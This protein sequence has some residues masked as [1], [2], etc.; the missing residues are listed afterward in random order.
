MKKLLL[1][2]SLTVAACGGSK[3][4]PKPTANT[5]PHFADECPSF[6]PG[7]YQE[8]GADQKLGTVKISLRKN[9][10]NMI[11]MKR[12]DDGEFFQ[13][14]GTVKPVK[15]GSAAGGCVKNAIKFSG[16][17]GL[18]KGAGTVSFDTDGNMSL[19]GELSESGKTGQGGKLTLT[20]VGDVPSDNQPVPVAGTCGNFLGEY[21]MPETDALP[22]KSFTVAAV[23]GAEGIDTE[24]KITLKDNTA[25]TITLLKVL[26]EELPTLFG[27]CSQAGNIMISHV[28]GLTVVDG[29]GRNSTADVKIQLLIVPGKSD[30]MRLLITD[31]NETEKVYSEGL[32]LNKK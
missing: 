30:Q 31:L 26:P 14:D 24:V 5:V 21:M 3:S 7:V 4:D 23:A 9:A 2:M 17:Q 19:E 13:V 18:Q 12:G 20:R 27:E 1:A 8:I 32:I 25:A 16:A 22:Y 10:K 11:E 15:G 28:A 6:T 29:N